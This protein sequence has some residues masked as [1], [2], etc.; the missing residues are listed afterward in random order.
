MHIYICRNK[1]MLCRST[2]WPSGGLIF[3]GCVCIPHTETHTHHL[4]SESK[5]K[6]FLFVWIQTHTCISCSKYFNTSSFDRLSNFWTANLLTITSGKSIL[7]SSRATV[8]ST[9]SGL[10]FPSSQWTSSTALRS[11]QSILRR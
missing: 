6:L 7:K 2:H 1:K 4:F 10:Q 11:I 5:H 8:R 3:L 9:S